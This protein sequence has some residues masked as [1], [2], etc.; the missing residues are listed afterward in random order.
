MGKGFRKPYAE[1]NS[2]ADVFLNYRHFFI[3]ILV[4][5]QNFS[6][7]QEVQSE[8]IQNSHAVIFIYGETIYSQDESFNKQISHNAELKN[9]E[10]SKTSDG[11]L[12]VV[13]KNNVDKIKE[14]STDKILFSE[15][16]ILASKC[17]EIADQ[18]PKKEVVIHINKA[19]DGDEFLAGSGTKS[20]SLIFPNN[21]FSASQD[22]VLFDSKAITQS[23]DYLHSN[24]FFYKNDLISLRGFISSF[25]VRPPPFS[26]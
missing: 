20:N 23:L 19:Y 8:E 11:Q 2:Y 9:V 7:A 24:S 16:E 13:A 4:L 26:I 15:K 5:F 18:L 21:D 22:F 25:S 12:N 6:F 1:I 14:L 3:L 17:K 10:I